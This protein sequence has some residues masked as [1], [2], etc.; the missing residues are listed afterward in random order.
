MV[1]LLLFLFVFRS[2]VVGKCV[3]A[4]KKNINERKQAKNLAHFCYNEFNMNTTKETMFIFYEISI[5]FFYVVAA[6][7]I[8]RQIAYSAF[9]L[10]QAIILFH[11]LLS[12]FYC[13]L[14]ILFFICI[15][16]YWMN[17]KKMEKN[18]THT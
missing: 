15:S 6:L 11:L 1:Y 17:K 16:F 13:R 8:I 5:F 12:H 9:L 2:F 4:D 14:F 18:N 3:P 7:S 10:I